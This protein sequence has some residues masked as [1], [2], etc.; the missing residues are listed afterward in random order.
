MTTSLLERL[1]R[2]VAHGRRQAQRL[3]DSVHGRQRERAVSV[4]CIGLPGD[5]AAHAGAPVGR[6]LYGAPA[7]SM[8]ALLAEQ[9][10]DGGPPIGRIVVD[11]HPAND[12]DALPARLARWAPC[13][14]MVRNVAPNA[15]LALHVAPE[16]ASIVQLVL[17]AYA[18]RDTE[19]NAPS[20]ATTLLLAEDATRLPALASSS[21]IACV[22]DERTCAALRR[23]LLLRRDTRLR[24]DAVGATPAEWMRRNASSNPLAAMHAALAIYGA[25]SP[26]ET[27]ATATVTGRRR[28]GADVVT[29]EVK[30]KHDRTLVWVDAPDRC[31]YETTL[32]RA[33]TRREHGRYDR[34]V[35]LGWHLS[36]LLGQMVAERGDPRLSVH[37]IGCLPRAERGPVLRV[38]PNGFTPLAG[39][40][41]ACVERRRSRSAPDF[42]WLE[43]HLGEDHGEAVVDWSID[44]SHDGQVFRGTWHA[45]RDGEPGARSAS[46]RVPRHDGPRRVC[47]RALGA[48]GR[49]SELLYVVVC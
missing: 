39:L 23:T 47:I 17:D 26:T 12:G 10:D 37:A 3:V 15:A 25:K 28:A 38:D 43:V 46:L 20:G 41:R 45:V 18:L 8:A 36:P 2:L 49:A 5:T 31:T 13:L 24:I 19:G 27:S 9:H 48:D 1:P 4:E 29:G 32:A 7:L 30:R 44:P 34:V 14:A 42:E 11:L 6:V 40:A 22:R 35:V 33:L 16:E 21:W